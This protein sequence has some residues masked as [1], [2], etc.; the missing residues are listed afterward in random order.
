[1]PTR[2]FRS[3][4]AFSFS[5]LLL[6][7]ATAGAAT[8]A[9]RLRLA[10]L[11]ADLAK[12][13]N[14]YLV[15]DPVAGRLEV[16]ARGME[17]TVVP[18]AELSLLTFRPLFGGADAPPLD[19]PTIWKV[20]Q[21]PGDT[22]RET[23]APTTLRPY[24]DEEEMEEPAAT[25]PGAKPAKKPG[26]EEKPSSYRVSLDNGWQLFLANEPPRLGWFRRFGAAV[27]DGW[28]R[29]RGAEPA[30]PP[31]VTLVVGADDARRLHHLFRTGMSILVAPVD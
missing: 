25:A 9:A 2:R 26:E 30:H 8:S 17:L 10:E 29:L 27:A 28:Q 19:A 11:E 22:D 15:L 16:K 23:I 20:R 13:P 24:S 1:M 18:V 7:A 4:L 6:L 21:G 12:Q 14:L 5:S 3:A 31:L